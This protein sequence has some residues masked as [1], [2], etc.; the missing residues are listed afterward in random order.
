NRPDPQYYLPAFHRTEA[1]RIEYWIENNN[2]LRTDPT[3]TADVV[4]QVFD[5]QHGATVDPAYPD[6]LNLSG[7]P[8]SSNVSQVELHVPSLQNSAIIATTPE[9]GTGTPSDPLQY[10]LT[11]TNENLREW[12]ASGLLAVRDELY[13][14]AAPSGRLPIPEQPSGFPYDT[15]DILDYSLYEMV[16]INFPDPTDDEQ[17]FDDELFVNDYPIVADQYGD[18]IWAEFFMDFSSSKFQY[19]WDFDY[20]GITFDVDGSGLPSP[21]HIF[22]AGYNNAALRVR[23]NA[24][25][26]REYIYEIP[27]YGEGEAYRAQLPPAGS[28]GDFLTQTVGRN[29]DLSQDNFYVAYTA[30]DGGGVRDVWLAVI[31]QTGTSTNIN[32]TDGFLEPA[33]NPSILVVEDGVNDGVYLLFE[34]FSTGDFKLYS[35]YGNLDGTGFDPSNI[36]PVI[37]TPGTSAYWSQLIYR[38]NRLFAYY[39]ITTT[40]WVEIDIGVSYSN[41]LGDT[42]NYHGIINDNLT[43][44][45]LRPTAV[46]SPIR[47]TIYCVWED[48]VNYATN[49]SDLIMAESF[50]GLDFEDDQNISSFGGL[51]YERY[52]QLTVNPAEL[53]ICYQGDDLSGN[54][55]AHLKVMKF[56]SG[57]FFDY[58]INYLSATGSFTRPSVSSPF[59][60]QYIVGCGLYNQTSHQL[61]MMVLDVTLGS[62]VDFSEYSIL[63]Y[64]TGNVDPSAAEVY[65]GVVSR[66]FGDNEGAENFIAFMNYLSGEILSPVPVELYLGDIEVAS[67]ITEGP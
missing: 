63:N 39:S 8:E 59:H 60:G 55:R 14:H 50:N 51:M 12:R 54:R 24:V 21:E 19:R 11:I 65:S 52:A 17:F 16:F 43:G 22:P 30:D 18:S 36:K 62:K 41:D 33:Y 45:Q 13:G 42:W 2:L 10:R 5:W 57:N 26:P 53:V 3:S 15:Q 34:S 28:T 6:P 61:R 64:T 47:V 23:T 25:P 31:D 35:T 58:K 7:I 56:Y 67:V 40:G 20:D 32:L 38:S 44:L 66:S 46:Y 37:T 1:W 29:V 49:G 4:V 9:S 27:V 48:Y